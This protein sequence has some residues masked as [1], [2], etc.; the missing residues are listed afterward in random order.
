MGQFPT[1]SAPLPEEPRLAR[2]AAAIADGSRARM[3]AHL[4]DGR[5]ASAGELARAASVTPATASA[6]LARLV[7]DALVACE[8]RGRHRYFRIADAEVAHALEALAL[9]AERGSH[10]RQWAAPPRARLR[11]ARCCYGHA[12]GRLG[13]ALCEALHAQG[14]LERSGA[15]RSTVT[16][17]GVSVLD[18]LGLD[19]AAWRRRSA[20]RGRAVAYPCLDWSERRDHLA[21]A[22]AVAILERWVELGWVRRGVPGDRALQV[23]PPGRQGLAAW[24]GIA[25]GDAERRAA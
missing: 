25:A 9:V 14:V 4:L 16:G 23:T 11:D 7:D 5:H 21:G 10:E 19:G 1:P 8:S 15:G 2:V 13:V 12:A 17:A 22:L 6:H 24:L 3:L 20:G 18:A